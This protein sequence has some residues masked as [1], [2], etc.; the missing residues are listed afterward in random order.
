MFVKY[1][2]VT[3]NAS[4]ILYGKKFQSKIVQK[5]KELIKSKNP[6]MEDD[7]NVRITYSKIK[8]KDK[9]FPK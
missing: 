1:F 4:K 8:P 6:K 9:K 7:D 5:A 3:D 2:P